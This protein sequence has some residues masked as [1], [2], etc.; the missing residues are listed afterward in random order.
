M[1]K[2]GRLFAGLAVGFVVWATTYRHLT[3]HLENV[4]W[5]YEGHHYAV[6]LH[7]NEMLQ[8]GLLAVMATLTTTK[9]MSILGKKERK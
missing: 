7:G 6:V 8:S 5:D 9:V 1:I 3:L 4:I 2:Y